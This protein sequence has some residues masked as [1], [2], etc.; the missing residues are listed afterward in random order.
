MRDALSQ[1]PVRQ[2]G[3]HYTDISVSNEALQ[4]F[5]TLLQLCGCALCLAQFLQ[6]IL[7]F[8][9]S[10]A[11]H[12]VL[13]GLQVGCI[14]IL[15]NRYQSLNSI[16]VQYTLLRVPLSPTADHHAGHRH[17]EAALAPVGVK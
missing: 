4:F 1:R 14:H 9:T 11:V 15:S 7:S 12:F 3:K 17:A 10:D 5:H 13:S 8:S 2:A 16:S 6:V